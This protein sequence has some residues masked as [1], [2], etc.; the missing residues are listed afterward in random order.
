[1]DSVAFAVLVQT[2]P[3]FYHPFGGLVEGYD[4]PNVM[5][6][7][8][9]YGSP[10]G[11]SDDI[12]I[13]ARSKASH[14]VILPVSQQAAQRYR[15]VIDAFRALHDKNRLP[16]YLTG[17][18]QA[19][20]YFEP[21]GPSLLPDGTEVLLP[22]T[23]GYYEGPRALMYTA[24]N[25]K[26]TDPDHMKP[27]GLQRI[28]INCVT[29]LNLALQLSGIDSSQID[30]GWPSFRRGVQVVSTLKNIFERH[31]ENIHHHEF[32]RSGVIT[33]PSSLRMIL[34]ETNS[35]TNVRFPDMLDKT[36]AF[37][38][39][40]EGLYKVIAAMPPLDTAPMPWPV[41]LRRELDFIGHN[42]P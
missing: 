3:T 11:F 17:S 16:Y 2:E 35:G 34:M 4:I 27:P 42:I 32:G 8:I 31:A 20:A 37:Y 18:F 6:Y 29:F 28:R 23:H 7:A 5:R 26:L 12:S 33:L 10:S 40:M 38:N 36:A 41:Y 24:R 1:M 14:A 13:N 15:K 39:G 30:S 21:P 25:E 22:D 9:D 19:N